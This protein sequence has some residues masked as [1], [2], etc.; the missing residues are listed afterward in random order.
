MC[1]IAGIYSNSFQV[2]EC[3]KDMT[4][5][6]AHRGPDA[7][8][9]YVNADKKI[10]LGHRRLSIL[11]L[12][13]AANQP[14]YSSCGRYVMVYNGEVYNYQDVRATIKNKRNIDFKTNGDTE[15]ILEAFALWGP[16][17]VEHLNGMF[18]YAILDLKEEK[19]FLF[20]DR[21]GIKPLYLFSD[22]TTFAFA[23]EI[24]AFK[25]ILDKTD[26]RLNCQALSNFLHLGFIPQEQTI[27]ASV[28]KLPSASWMEL[29]LKNAGKVDFDTHMY[30][31]ASGFI[32][33]ET[34]NNE[35]QAKER[36]RELLIQ[37][38]TGRLLAD[39]P[40]GTFLSGGIDSSTV[41]AIA[42]SISDKPV[43][44]F[45]IGFE[46]RKFNEADY[47]SSVAKHLGTDHHELILSEQDA[48]AEI[49]GLLR[50]YDQPFADSSSIPTLLVS[51]MARKHVTVA[52]SGDGG[53]EQFLGYGMYNWASRLS[54][55]MI[56]TFR[57]P[58]GW[59]LKNTGNNR[60]KRGALV[61]GYPQGNMKS[62]IFSQEQY[63][64]S[65]HELEKLI[66]PET[67][68]SAALHE[69]YQS[70]VKLG[71]EE[72][73]A[74]FD[75]NNYLK[76]DL[77]VK[78]DMASMNHSLEVR[79]PLLDHNIVEFSLGLHHKF[80]KRNKESKYLLKQV[81]FD[82]VPKALFD[83]PKWGFAVPMVKWLKTDLKYL[84]DNHL[85]KAS[86][87]QAGIVQYQVVDALKKRYLNGE[88]YLYNRLW[89]LI[90]LHKWLK[91]Y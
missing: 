4:N 15:V 31:D 89:A 85:S 26:S 19:L 46:D 63:F 12:T 36:L 80:K 3:L 76:D 38:V 62:H 84:L 53:D 29:D 10:A 16:A 61:M 71:P 75:I 30:W 88:D 43:Q 9:Y 52:L 40:L 2:E 32:G 45:S 90:I 57:Y 66:L 72:A 11:D 20:R 8:G 78:V 44:T 39:V 68:K 28:E 64:F 21:L 67:F 86:I 79:V 35:S 41:T 70:N 14:F 33:N 23:S 49:E 58:L 50:I 6:L 42:Q 59:L 55:P 82:Y 27:Y 17:S 77:L 73:Q 37:S 1:G 83:R 54:N 7:E 65:N 51:K 18:A 47:A 91:E 24:K 22:G 56:R 69:N 13:D 60:L 48:L 74:F 25:N 81:L 34:F 87:E 5:A